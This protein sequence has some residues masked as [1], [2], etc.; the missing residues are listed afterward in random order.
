MKLNAPKLTVALTLLMLALLSGCTSLGP[1]YQK[2]DTLPEDK[3]LV[4]I[5]RPNS[6][7]GGGVSYDVKVGEKPIMTLYNGGYYPYFSS[8]GEVEFWAKSESRSAVTIDVETGKTYFLKGT[9][10]VG[11]LVGRPHLTIVSSETG[12]SEIKECKLIPEPKDE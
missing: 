7:V 9:V 11:F 5:Y 1:I 12:M 6:F 8:P 4:Y 3:G 2:V 10:G